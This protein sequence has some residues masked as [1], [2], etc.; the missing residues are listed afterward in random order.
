VEWCVGVLFGGWFLFLWVWGVWG[1][2]GGVCYGLV[3][4]VVCVCVCSV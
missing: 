1:V 2:C 3:W 4:C